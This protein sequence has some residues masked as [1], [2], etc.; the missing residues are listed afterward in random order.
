ML[1]AELLRVGDVYCTYAWYIEYKDL[2]KTP[3][4]ALLINPSK[5]YFHLPLVVSVILPSIPSDLRKDA[6]P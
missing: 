3:T 1:H 2:D 4:A 5:P 6:P